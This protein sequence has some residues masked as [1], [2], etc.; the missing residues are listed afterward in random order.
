MCLGQQVATTTGLRPFRGPDASPPRPLDGRDHAM[1]RYGMLCHRLCPITP[2]EGLLCGQV[3]ILPQ[4]SFAWL[5]EALTEKAPIWRCL[6]SCFDH[7]L[8]NFAPVHW[9]CQALHKKGSSRRAAQEV[10]SMLRLSLR[11][12]MTVRRRERL[13]VDH[14]V[15]PNAAR[16]RL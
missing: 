14:Q 9:E 16:G 1:H 4:K 3:A 11:G 13:Q 15:K 2:L 6:D 12:A 8:I 10:R 7:P 5:L